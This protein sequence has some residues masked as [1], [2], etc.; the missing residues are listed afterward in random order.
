M[1]DLECLEQAA[2]RE[3]NGNSVALRADIDTNT[4]LQRL[5][6]QHGSLLR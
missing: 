3:A 2:V 5:G 4:Q 6:S 1:R